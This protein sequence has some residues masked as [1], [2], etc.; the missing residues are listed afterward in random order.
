MSRTTRKRPYGFNKGE[1]IHERAKAGDY[2]RKDFAKADIYHNRDAK[3]Y[4]S[5]CMAFNGP[6][7]YCT[8]ETVGDNGRRWAKRGAARIIRNRFKKEIAAAL[9][10]SGDFLLPES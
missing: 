9:R 3:P 8:W 4:G 1:W 7:G 2:D 6:K 5:V 10:E